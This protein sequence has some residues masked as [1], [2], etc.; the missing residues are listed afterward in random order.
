MIEQRAKAQGLDHK[1]VITGS[2]ATK[3]VC[4]TALGVA[5][6]MGQCGLR[7]AVRIQ[8]AVCAHQRALVM[9]G[10]QHLGA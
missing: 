9:T 8:K 5:W 2:K 6:A 10:A 1:V 4:R 7:M 3:A